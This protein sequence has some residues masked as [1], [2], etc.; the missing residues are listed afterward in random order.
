MRRTRRTR[1]KEKELAP[2]PIT[3]EERAGRKPLARR[4]SI[5]GQAVRLRPR[6]RCQFQR[7]GAKWALRMWVFSQ[8]LRQRLLCRTPSRAVRPQCR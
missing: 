2:F 1:C 3:L 4:M 5:S 8:P 7:A 6:L